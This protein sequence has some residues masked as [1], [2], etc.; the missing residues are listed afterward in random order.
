[1]LRAA[2]AR[3]ES[4]EIAGYT[5]APA[6]ALPLEAAELELPAGYAGRVLWAEVGAE[7]EV[8]TLL[9]DAQA[10]VQRWR[11]R[12][13]NVEAEGVNGLPFWQT[14]EIAECPAL[15]QASRGY[16]ERLAA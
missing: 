4:I 1:V 7:Q 5:V 12:V 13:S 3:G 2:L 11:E 6:L 14:L 16:L 15:G 9:P 10:R 8:G